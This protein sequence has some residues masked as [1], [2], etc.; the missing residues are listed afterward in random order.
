MPGPLARLLSDHVRPRRVLIVENLINFLTL[1]RMA[2]TVGVCGGGFGVHVLREIGWLNQCD[3]FYWGD[4]DTHGFSILSDLRGL[5]PHTRSLMMDR[6][7]FDTYADYVV[8]V[9][10]THKG[11]FDHLTA[12]EDELAR[13]V[14]HNGLRLEQEHIPHADAILAPPAG[15]VGGCGACIAMIYAAQSRREAVSPTEAE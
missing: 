13:H 3:V 10:V 15:V 11:R 12:S 5:F 2:H 7:T 14:T 6:A 4:V 9:S 1:P 8:S